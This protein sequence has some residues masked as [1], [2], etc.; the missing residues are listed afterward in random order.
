MLTG[1]LGAAFVKGLQGSGKVMKAA[2]CAKHYAVHSG[3]EPDRHHFD[4]AVSKKDL[5]ETYL[6]AFRKL[7]EA[8]VESVMGAYNRVNGEPA[9]A[10]KTLLADILRGEWGFDGHVVSDCGAIA[11]IHE[12]HEVTRK[13]TESVAMAIKRGCD[14]N[15]GVCYGKA[16]LAVREGLLAESDIDVAVRRLLTTRFRL[17]MFDPPKTDPFRHLS[18]KIV[19]CDAHRKL[20]REAAAKSI[21]LLKNKGGVLP[22]SKDA[23][24]ISVIGSTATR[25]DALWSN[26]FG[27]T[28]RL[29]TIL[30]GIVGRVGPATTVQYY[31]GY[32]LER[33]EDA[34]NTVVYGL[35]GSAQADA[36]VAVCGLT[37]LFESEEGDAVLSER[38]G[39]RV[40]IGLPANQVQF[41][42]GLSERCRQRNT[43]LILV[44][45][46]GSA[47]ALG[48]LE[49]LA[50]AILFV[51]YPGEEGGNAVADVLFGDVSPSGRL[52]VTFVKS[53]EQL[54]PFEDYS[55]ER[56][57]YRYMKDE[58]LYPF[59]FGLS[60]TTF[61]YGGLRL[62]KRAVKAG[63]TV[64]AEVTVTNA[65]KRAAEEVVQAYLTDLEASTRTPQ[66]ALKAFRRVRI[67]AGK[68]KKSRIRHHARHD[69]ARERRRQ[70][71]PRARTIPRHHRRL[72]ARPA[73]HRSRRGKAG[74]GGVRGE[75]TAAGET[76]VYIC[77]TSSR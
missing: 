22:L 6:P 41:L 33:P 23:R 77:G 50:D 67:A 13:V 18:T 51:W 73:R 57:T 53:V 26:Y 63:E 49:E 28:D 25:L 68:S 59:G 2:A 39:D 54:P 4:A 74:G 20:A 40:S 61:R 3:P 30:E 38:D 37:P 44:L 32:F 72:L 76:A 9:C 71:R 34:R 47:I 15:C 36:V 52:P 19:D 7:V 62:S 16:G 11:D 8:K 14:L 70:V 24:Q 17:G 10:S 5:F 56:R 75:V 12:R 43:P 1:T 66:W 45:T 60:Y 31:P 69:D 27:V 64:R 46:G 58:P 48:E 35:G 29:V 21:V 42:K 55:M 65:G